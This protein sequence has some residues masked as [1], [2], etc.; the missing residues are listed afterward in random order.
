M[1]CPGCFHAPLPVAICPNCNFDVHKPQPPQRLQIGTKLNSQFIVGRILGAPGGFGVTYL[2]WDEHLQTKV[3][4]K[5]FFPGDLAQRLHDHV[6]V[7]PLLPNR[8]AD[9]QQG[10]DGFLREARFLAQLNHNNIVRIRTFFKEHGTAYMVMDYYEGKNLEEYFRQNGQLSE[11][12][13]LAIFLPILSGLKEVH[14]LGILHRDIK[15]ENIYLTHSGKALLLDFGTARQELNQK[16]RHFTVVLTRGF[17]PPEQ[18]SERG[19]QGVWT[20]IYAIG[21]TLYYLTTGKIPAD[22]LDRSHEDKYIPPQQLNPSLSTAFSNAVSQCLMLRPEKRPNSIQN[23]ETLLNKSS[24]EPIQSS[25]RAISEQKPK[26]IK[27]ETS[28]KRTLSCPAC[29]CTN[30]IPTGADLA[31]LRCGKCDTLLLPK[32]YILVQC[33][34]CN[35]KNKVNIH[36]SQHTL[37][38]G[39]CGL[40]LN[41]T[42]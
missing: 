10:L 14:H 31:Q 33:K 34:T 37:W 7:Y 5:E 23:L 41:K 30:Q 6:S 3:A 42:S 38:C 8:T 1:L 20:D 16:S 26:P 39:K 4:I 15:P 17:A 21:A 13:A 32:P 35:A 25:R 24:T 29:K 19:K 27:S 18:Y 12:E 22:A 9:F 11:Q 28:L 40:P 36:V 2:A